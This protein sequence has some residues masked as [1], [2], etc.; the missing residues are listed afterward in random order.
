MLDCFLAAHLLCAAHPPYGLDSFFYSSHYLIPFSFSF[1][2]FAEP[3]LAI[4]LRAL[5]MPRLPRHGRIAHC[6][7]ICYSLPAP[8]LST[9]IILPPRQRFVYCRPLRIGLTPVAILICSC[10]RRP[11]S[12]KEL[13]SSIDKALCA[14]HINSRCLIPC[15]CQGRKR[16][17]N[18]LQFATPWGLRS[19]PC[20][21]QTD[22][23][24][25]SSLS[26]FF[27]SIGLT[28]PFNRIVTR[29][30]SLSTDSRCDGRGPPSQVPSRLCPA[31]PFHY[32][33]ATV[34][35]WPCL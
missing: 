7:Y 4:R 28:R 21:K 2:F 26:L 18:P 19:L 23:R 20:C 22:I 29:L 13:S 17:L 24:F 25:F 33:Q 1:F 34:R 14:Q 32:S 15:I 6:V 5:P 12:T 30:L 31:A 11:S 3:D 27:L 10:G 9:I 8:T 16:A 35:S